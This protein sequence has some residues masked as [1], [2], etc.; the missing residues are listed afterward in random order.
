MRHCWNCYEDRVVR[1]LSD[2]GFDNVE[3]V[4]IDPEALAGW[5]VV[6]F[7]QHQCAVKGVVT[8]TS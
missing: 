1:L 7:T 4:A 3:A 5:P 8:K 6:A 2:A